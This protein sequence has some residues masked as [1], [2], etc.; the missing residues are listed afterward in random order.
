MDSNKTKKILPLENRTAVTPYESFL[1]PLLFFMCVINVPKAQSSSV[2]VLFYINIHDKWTSRSVC[3][4]IV[5]G[6]PK[7]YFTF[8]NLFIYFCHRIR[9]HNYWSGRVCVHCLFVV[10]FCFSLSLVR[11]HFPVRFIYFCWILF[12]YPSIRALLCQTIYNFLPFFPC[13]RSPAISL[14]ICR[15][16]PDERLHCKGI[17]AK[18]SSPS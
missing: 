15:E 6:N 16:C 4:H 18:C 5:H 13:F 7:Q 8:Y 3:A 14:E 17:D 10:L 9:A 2:P 1:L 11:V 12:F